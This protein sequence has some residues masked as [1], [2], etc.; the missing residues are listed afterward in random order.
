MHAVAVDTPG[1]KGRDFDITSF[2][3]TV[4]RAHW[5]P[6]STD[7]EISSPTVLMGPGWGSAG[8]T[9]DTK[10]GVLGATTIGSIRDAGYNVL[11]W[12]PRGFGNSTGT[13]TIDS[14]DYEGRDVEQLIDWVATRPE[15]AL[16]AEDDPQMGMVGASYGGGIQLVTAALDCRIDAIVPVIAWNSL[17]TSLDKADT[18]KTGWSGLLSVSSAGRKL[19]P[20]VVHAQT[21]ENA[22]GTID[23]TDKAWFAAHDPGVGDI[24]IPTLIIQGTV[25][26]L[27]TLDE[28]IANYDILSKNNVPTSMVWFCGGHGVCLTK[29]GDQQRVVAAAVAWLN[30]YVKRDTSVDT[31]PGF[32]FVDQDGVTYTAPT[33]S[34]GS[35]DHSA[36]AAVSATGSGTL[37]LVATGGAGPVTTPGPNGGQLDT[38]IDQITPAKADSA[39]NVPIASTLK[40]DA[41]IISAP[42]LTLSYSGTVAAGDRPMRVFAQL[43]DDTTGLVIG[44]QITPIPVT[45]DGQ[46]H[47]VAVPLEAI[48]FTLHPGATVTLQLVA[49]TVAYAQPRLGGSVTFSA[50]GIDLPVSGGVTRQ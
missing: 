35:A 21:T 41:T 32:S 48:A 25:D 33:Y 27:F 40:A 10:V 46:S 49:T 24:T 6:R 22:T 50:I 19:D 11:T 4:I 30:R 8:D 7:P 18:P 17:V 3:G 43:V 47:T 12:D 13:I 1:A 31:G 45:L 37:Q 16:D 26:T 2:D 29:A 15:A 39:V 20:T 14:P 34:P 23:A 44:N 28:G 38:F 9:N 5:F 36:P 42:Q